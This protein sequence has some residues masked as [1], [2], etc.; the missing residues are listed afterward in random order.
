MYVHKAWIVQDI[1]S[2]LQ[3]LY[4]SL[5]RAIPTFR[6]T[7]ICKCLHLGYIGCDHVEGIWHFIHQRVL[8]P[9]RGE[10]HIPIVRICE[11]EFLRNVLFNVIQVLDKL[12]VRV[13]SIREVIALEIDEKEEL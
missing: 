8:L 5:S 10:I 13:F 3:E 6:D 1:A 2:F 9:D 4:I 7:Q 12:I 11:F